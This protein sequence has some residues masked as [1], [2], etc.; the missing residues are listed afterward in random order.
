MEMGIKD[1]FEGP[2]DESGVVAMVFAGVIVA[3]LLQVVSCVL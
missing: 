1:V 2:V 3:F